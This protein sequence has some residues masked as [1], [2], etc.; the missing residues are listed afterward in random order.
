MRKK[1]NQSALFLL[2]G[3]GALAYVFKDKLMNLYKTMF[4]GNATVKSSFTL[5]PVISGNPLSNLLKGTSTTPAK[6]ATAVAPVYQPGQYDQADAVH[7]NSPTPTFPTGQFD[8]AD[9]Q[10]F[11]TGQT[12]M[13]DADEDSVNS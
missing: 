4:S 11:L 13:P 9:A 12:I 1:K 5:D 6:S 7:F 10:H 8:D 3:V 2:L